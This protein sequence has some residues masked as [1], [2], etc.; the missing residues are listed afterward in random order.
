MEGRKLSKAGSCI[1]DKKYVKILETPFTP[2]PHTTLSAYTDN[3]IYSIPFP[4]FEKYEWKSTPIPPPPPPPP[5]I[6]GFPKVEWKKIVEKIVEKSKQEPVVKLGLEIPEP[7]TIET[8]KQEQAQQLIEKVIEKAVEKQT[9]ETPEMDWIENKIYEMKLAAP[10]KTS[11]I[12]NKA[13]FDRIKNAKSKVD[14]V[15]CDRLP[16]HPKC[17]SKKN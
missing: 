15:N 2:A 14:D 4:K 1:K 5:K 3:E 7:N 17:K 10:K 13:Y 16:N 8:P 11:K 6:P 9:S 12:D